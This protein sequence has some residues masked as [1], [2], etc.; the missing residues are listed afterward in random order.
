MPLAPGTKLGPYEIQSPLGAGGMGEVY[1]ARDTRLERTVALKILPAQLSSD[2]AR[3]QRFEREAKTISSLNHPH[4][5]TLHDIGSQ[6]GVDYLV[7]ECVE[8]DTLVKRLE[9]GP[10]PLE[11]VLKYGAQIADALD[12]A[13]R[14]GIVHR[15]LKPGNI[16][17]TATG[18]KL[19]DFGLAKLA[20]PLTSVA[21]LTA[22]VT[23]DSPVTEQGM[24]VGTFQ[25]MSP[26]Q[27]EVKELDGRSDIFSLGAVL[28][29]MLTGHRAFEGKSQLSVAS[30]I[31]EREPTPISSIKPMTPPALDHAIRRCLAKDPE[32]RWQSGRD[33]QG[34]LIWIGENAS[35]VATTRVLGGKQ[36]RHERLA[37]I[38]A[39][40]FAV[41][42]LAAFWLSWS[43]P[44]LEERRLEFKINPPAGTDFLL[45]S[46]GG[47][48]ISPDGHSIA[49]VAVSS[50]GQKLWIRPLDSTRARELPGTENAQYPFWS[51]DSKSLGFFA[52]GKLKR[53]DLAGGSPVTLAEAPNP[54][55][56][57]WGSQGI[58]VFSPSAVSG[59]WQVVE[60]GGPA[61]PLTT[62]DTGRSEFTHRW[63]T[64]LPDGNRFI[65][66]GR[67]AN[68]GMSSIYLSSL[69]RPQERTLLIKET[70]AAA[71]YSPAHGKHTE[72]LY[73]LRQQALVAQ[74]FDSKHAR[75]LGD[76]V[77][78]PGAEM[79]ALTVTLAR[80][81]VS[82]SNDG[83]ILFGSGS[84][85]YQLTWVDRE[86]K[87][88]S[89]VGEPDRYA[90]LRIS[91][92][93]TRIATVLADSSSR[94]DLWL[95]ELSR[96]IPSRLTFA[97]VF[98]TGAWSPDGQ[99]IGYHLL[100]DRR[101]LQK[102]ANGAGQEETLL[103]SQYTV[104]LND[105]SPDGRF[106]VYTQQ[107]PDGR[108]ELWLLPL[109]GDRKPQPFLKTT[110]NEMQGEVSP[111]GKWIAYTSDES[112]GSNEVYVTSFPVG[113]PRWRVSS[114]GG[115]FPRW[116]RDG[117]ELFYRALEGTLMV[118]PVRTVS[119][120]LEFGPPTALFRIP[121][122]S[123]MFA[124]PYDVGLDG[125][126]I[127]ALLPSRVGGDNPSIT[128]LVD[129]DAKP[130]P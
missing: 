31:L 69:E 121:E 122:P 13:H 80:S 65:Y 71:A 105:W 32:Q 109:S 2:P 98:G 24:I 74:P 115:S 29:E 10:L 83:T 93:G 8:G 72:Y 88:L 97:G 114:G 23:Q 128:V 36:G 5:C 41:I 84:D 6:N 56:G 127:L 101:L 79:V 52:N 110:F 78:V 63:P 53:L 50:G 15:D 67:G 91:P 117:K 86:G 126:R 96:A 54:R 43:Q 61:R 35:S 99:R 76:G 92:D 89:T 18:A 119:H 9:K 39:A 11:Q 42:A 51:P 116:S 60:S 17:L 100:S 49:F 12:K 1:R 112:G 59:L 77:P 45:E 14:A 66:V 118:A 82:V 16:I 48:A 30:A 73:W 123:G 7:M 125:R 108:S 120:G 21:T 44:V 106:L 26:E 4:I 55:G 25:Y 104:Y 58:V 85:R 47:N 124:Y 94:S 28:Y 75:L 70:S 37:W 34:E 22:A 46:G 81:S 20:A 19:L 64:F 27:V 68:G 129:W 3:K 102:N 90:S 40:V 103:Q 107:S 111:D 57:S 95:L 130:R 38:A 113:G 87:V 62:V 33:L